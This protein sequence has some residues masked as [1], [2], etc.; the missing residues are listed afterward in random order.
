VVLDLLSPAGIPLFPA[1]F[2]ELA[3]RLPALVFFAA[4][5]RAAFLVAFDAVVAG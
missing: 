3:D 2:T 5:W 1:A 4:V